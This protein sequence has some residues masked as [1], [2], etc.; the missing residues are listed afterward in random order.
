MHVTLPASAG[1]SNMRTFVNSCGTRIVAVHQYF[2]G[3]IDGISMGNFPVQQTPYEDHFEQPFLQDYGAGIDPCIPEPPPPV[4]AAP[5]LGKTCSANEPNS[6][7][8]QSV[9]VLSGNEYHVEEDFRYSDLLSFRR[10][11]NSQANYIGVL[12][13]KWQ[14][15]FERKLLVDGNTALVMR[16]DGRVLEF[17]ASGGS[18]SSTMEPVASLESVSQGGASFRYTLANGNIEHYDA[19]GLWL[20][21]ATPNGETITAAYANG[22]LSE[23]TDNFGR[24]LSFDYDPSTDQLRDVTI[25]AGLKISFAYNG[26]K[27]LTDVTLPGATE[28]REYRYEDSQ[29]SQLLTGMLNGADER[30]MTWVYDAQAR[31]TKEYSGEY[32]N[33]VADADK[34]NIHTFDYTTPNQTTVTNT[35]GKEATFHYADY[36][37]AKKI[38][39]IDGAASTHCAAANQSYTYYPSGQLHTKTDWK[40]NVT[41]YE[42]DNQGREKER[43]E[44]KGALVERT[45]TTEWHPTL[46]LR[47]RIIEAGRITTYDYDTNGQLQ[48]TTLE[49]TAGYVDANGLTVYAPDRKWGYTYQDGQLATIDGPLPGAADTESLE[50]LTNGFFWKRTNALG[51]VTEILDHNTWGLPKRIKDPNGTETKLIYDARGQLKESV[52]GDNTA[53]PLTT[54]FGYDS[55][56]RLEI[57]TLPN[58]MQYTYRYDAVGRLETITA[59]NGDMI[60]YTPDTAGNRTATEITHAT[61]GLVYTSS[62]KFDELS[63]LREAVDHTGV[64]HKYYHDAN[65]NVEK[66]TDRKGYQILRMHD[67]L[68]RL[69]Q[70]DFAVNESVVYGYN[71]LD[72]LTSVQDQNDNTTTYQYDGLGNLR[73]MTSP[74]SGTTVFEAYDEAG[75]LKKKVDA[76][77]NITEYEYDVLGRLKAVVYP[78]T[79][80]SIPATPTTVQSGAMGLADSVRSA[81]SPVTCRCFMTSSGV[82]LSNIPSFRARPTPSTMATMRRAIWIVSPCQMAA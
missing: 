46:N 79:R 67:A 53:Q 65:G 8:G 59:S 31:V 23:V 80:R 5:E 10:V 11:Y 16:P 28:A 17:T 76:N 62:Q 7:V 22:Q 51:H 6:Q 81:T 41:E 36:G 73:S 78:Q 9:N 24:N 39:T 37:G 4:V 1:L 75:N 27:M 52:S 13:P 71:A 15:N 82:S 63:R 57:L 55:V 74:D 29:D 77:G 18:W 40:G 50:Y 43:I 58:G 35:L 56:G 26:T 54:G 60:K 68:D 38:S 49:D 42:Y 32:D 70:V 69:K 2:N 45:I 19:A 30:M 64:A 12:G 48:F 25:E 61:S 14:H 47:E 33:S 44:A 72:Q 3:T 66:E 21:T 20:S 34:A